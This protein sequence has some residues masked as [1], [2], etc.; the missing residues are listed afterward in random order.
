MS[1]T[2]FDDIE[3]S[4]AGIE[5]GEINSEAATAGQVLTADGAGGAGWAGVEIPEAVV[6]LGVGNQIYSSNGSVGGAASVGI[7][8]FVNVAG[9][10]AVGV[11]STVSVSAAS[12]VGIGFDVSVSGLRGIGIGS[13]VNVNGDTGVAIGYSA[14]A[15]QSA[16]AIGYSARA[17][18]SGM[19]FGEASYAYAVGGLAFGNGAKAVGVNSV[20]LG[21]SMNNATAN[22]LKIGWNNITG[23]AHFTT[24]TPTAGVKTGTHFL[25]VNLGGTVY[26]LLVSNV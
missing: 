26:N 13:A 21:T 18:T 17:V 4:Q 23:F 1:K 20:A 19:A 9:A 16:I 25:P 11:G 24:F 10:D 8:N 5:A 2:N 12:G 22:S 6:L 3:L 15:G 14:H 7:G